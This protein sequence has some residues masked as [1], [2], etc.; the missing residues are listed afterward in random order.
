MAAKF[1]DYYD[2]LGVPRT[3]SLEEIKLAYRKLAREHH[4]DLHPEKEKERH[5]RRMQE[6]NEAYSVLSSPENRAKYDQFGEHWK[7]GPPPPPPQ[8]EARGPR[9]FS[10]AF[11][12]QETSGF[13]DF[14]RD[15]FQQSQGGGQPFHEFDAAEL[16]IEAVLELTLEESVKGVEKLLRLMTTGLCQNC[17][18]TGRTA[19]ALCPVCGGIGEI[20]KPRDVTTKIPPGLLEGGRIRLKGQGSEGQRARG[21]LFLTI[22]L[23]ADPRYTVIGRDLRTDINIEPWQAVLGSEITVSTL[24]GPVRVRIPKGTHNGNQLRLT[25]KGLGKPN[26]RGTLYIRLLVDI[27]EHISPEAEALYKKLKEES[28]G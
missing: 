1:I 16:D 10:G 13:S 3:A 26:D 23:I 14:F 11:S 27:P 20:R 8:R 28:H 2:L 6:A 17:H 9:D 5:T 15:Y 19:N 7:E 4:P 25:G 21:D 18:G 24:D 22:H 12:G